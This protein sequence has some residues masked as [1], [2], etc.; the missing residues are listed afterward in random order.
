M[1]AAIPLAHTAHTCIHTHACITH[2]G[3]HACIPMHAHTHAHT[4][5][6]H[7]LHTTHTPHT[8]HTTHTLHTTHTTHTHTHTH[9]QHT[10]P[11]THT[12]CSL[13]QCQCPSSQYCRLHCNAV[14]D[15]VVMVDLVLPYMAVNSLE[16]VGQKECGSQEKACHAVKVPPPY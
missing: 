12:H 1:L 13:Q 8:Q 5:H 2:Y 14:Q 9:T 4:T 7:T 6:V 16:W 10:T 3:T 11:H 15:D